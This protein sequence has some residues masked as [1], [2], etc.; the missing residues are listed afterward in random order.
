MR[1]IAILLLVA[2]SSVVMAEDDFIPVPEWEWVE[3]VNSVLQ[4]Y[5]NGSRQLG[6]GETCGIEYS[7]KLVELS[8]EAG[9]VLVRYSAPGISIGTSCPDGVRFLISRTQ[10]DSMT[11][12]Y[13][14]VA[15][16][17]TERLNLIARLKER[18]GAASDDADLDQR[19]LDRADEIIRNT[20]RTLQPPTDSDAEGAGHE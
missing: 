19:I 16:A 11:A 5:S 2:A 12:A 18:A 17:K 20:A 4:K 3:V 13:I 1:T 6:P 7:G 15:H 14:E 8:A 9:T 10:L